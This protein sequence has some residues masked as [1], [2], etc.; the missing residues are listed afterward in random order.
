MELL[1]QSIMQK[2]K[3]CYLTGTTYN[4]HKHHIFY[5]NGKRKLSEEWGCWCWLTG[6]LHNQGNK[7]VHFN[8]PLD[9]QLKRDCQYEFEALYGHD[10][11]ME[12][13]RRNYI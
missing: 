12:G 10:K 1:S 3:S 7:G 13:G 6:K 9:L 11:F 8:H 2:D 4:L 5:G